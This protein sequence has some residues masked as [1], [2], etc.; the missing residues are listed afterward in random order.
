MGSP[1]SLGDIPRP[2]PAAGV[3][4]PLSQDWLQERET[5]RL[6]AEHPELFPV[7]NFFCFPQRSYFPFGA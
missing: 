3:P 1:V 6:T 5:Q 4:A 2:V 7:N